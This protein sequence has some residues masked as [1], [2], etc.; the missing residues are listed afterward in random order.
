[1]A[2]QY[3]CPKCGDGAMK[4]TDTSTHPAPQGGPTPLET[5]FMCDKCQYEAPFAEIQKSRS[6]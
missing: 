3:K 2:D 5:K 6:N 1:M 4:R